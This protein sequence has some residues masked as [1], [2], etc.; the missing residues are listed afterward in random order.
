LQTKGL[1]SIRYGTLEASIK[2]P[3]G[4]GLWP[5][6]WTLGADIDAVGWP[7][8][9]EVDVMENIGSDAFTVYGSIHGPQSG[10]SAGPYRFV[11]PKRSPV[12]LSAGFHVYGVTWTPNRIVFSLDG[13]PYSTRTPESLSAGQRWVFDKPF[14]LLLNLAVGGT[15][16]GSP[17]PSTRF[18]ATML[19]DWV[20]VYS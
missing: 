5:A 16:P 13:I 20:R 10:P 8:S 2:V 3:R 4:A 15:W 1:F 6:F 12:A 14:F 18:P 17:N 7:R 9:G 11:A 19:V